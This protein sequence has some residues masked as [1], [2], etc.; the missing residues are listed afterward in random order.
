M[1]GPKCSVHLSTGQPTYASISY[2]YRAQRSISTEVSGAHA[3]IL[4]TNGN[5]TY[6]CALSSP[7]FLRQHICAV[8]PG[9]THSSFTSTQ[10][11]WTIFLRTVINQH[12]YDHK[13]WLLCDIKEWMFHIFYD[14]ISTLL[15]RM[16][17]VECASLKH[18][19]RHQY[20]TW[21]WSTNTKR[22]I[23]SIVGKKKSNRRILD[24][25]QCQCNCRRMLLRKNQIT[26]LIW[27]EFV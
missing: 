27:V 13:L 21:S 19:E 3:D 12:S 9:R 4:Q 25:H 8:M 11:Q 15:P 17:C 7:H 24:S 18:L 14:W 10:R 5:L 23:H 16:S 2:Q 26:I 1:R 22:K 20:W 6:D